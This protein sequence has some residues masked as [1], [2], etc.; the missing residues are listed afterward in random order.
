MGWTAEGWGG[1]CGGYGGI[2]PPTRPRPQQQHAPQPTRTHAPAGPCRSRWPAAAPPAAGP[3]AP[4][5]LWFVR[6]VGAGQSAP[7]VG[8][9]M[10]PAV[11][12]SGPT[13]AT[14]RVIGAVLPSIHPS[15]CLPPGTRRRVHTT[16]HHTTPHRPPHDDD[17]HPK[18]RTRGV[19][20][21]SWRAL[22][23]F[24][25]SSIVPALILLAFVSTCSCVLWGRC[26]RQ[27]TVGR[28]SKSKRRRRRKVG[29]V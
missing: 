15:T 10:D 8:R 22:Y 1:V 14:V 17:F 19:D 5:S 26:Q 27:S 23:C 4:T 21:P 7:F 29:R 16:S 3:P 20:V 9:F 18:P 6:G 13:R 28:G 25:I 12:P 2:D 11:D 24:S